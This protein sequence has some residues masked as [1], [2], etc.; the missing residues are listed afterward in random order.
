[1]ENVIKCGECG[2]N[3]PSGM[4]ICP[5][6]GCPVEQHTDGDSAQQ[7]SSQSFSGH[8]GNIRCRK[9]GSVIPNSIK[10]CPNCGCPVAQQTN[11]DMK[12]DVSQ[13]SD[14]QMGSARCG[15]CGS[16]IPN[17]ATACPNCGCPVD[18]EQA[19][20]SNMQ[21]ETSVR[22]DSFNEE[23]P[24]SPFNSNSWLFRD[25]WPLYNYPRGEL[26]ERHPF[27]DWLFEPWH[28][29]CDSRRNKES[30]DVI[31][32]I[33]YFFNLLFKIWF[34]GLVWLVFKIW[35]IA[36]LIFTALLVI[37]GTEKL[38]HI[39]AGAIYCV[40]VFFFVIIYIVSIGK[41]L[42]RYWPQLHKTFRRVSKRYWNAMLDK[43]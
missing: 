1:M 12:Q 31:N 27:I 18:D 37:A 26:Y 40:F 13:S 22:H 41:S 24:Y 8:M 35:W 3:I 14:G 42:H 32:N 43:K 5:N 28:L 9:C 7:N 2:F 21:I 10:F 6:C 39:I 11:E 23:E 36:L 20:E 29:T 16:M 38:T 30:Y 4:K 15:E 25:P 33:F 17:G 34:Y 19:T